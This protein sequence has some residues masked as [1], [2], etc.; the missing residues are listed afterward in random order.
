MEF[1]ELLGPKRTALAQIDIMLE[2]KEYKSASEG[3]KLY[4]KAKSEIEAIQADLAGLHDKKN[5]W[6][7]R[8]DLINC[9]SELN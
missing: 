8:I 6:I 2:K 1:D 3:R 5:Q 9:Y 4:E 7:K